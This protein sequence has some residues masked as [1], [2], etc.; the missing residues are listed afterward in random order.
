MQQRELGSEAGLEALPQSFY[1]RDA[2]DVA[3]DLI[4]CY[5]VRLAPVAG[6]AAG[7]A[8]GSG[9]GLAG[10]LAARIV[11]TEAYLPD[12]PASHSYRGR[13]LRTAAM[14]GPAG[15]AYVYFIYGTHYCLN[16][17]VG[18]EAHGAAVLLRAAVPVAGLPEMAR[19]RYFSG[20]HSATQ[21]RA[22]VDERMKGRD[23]RLVN[24]S[25]D[26]FSR[27]IRE[28]PESEASVA[29][30][31]WMLDGQRLRG[32]CNGPGKLAQAFDVGP[33]DNGQPLTDRITREAKRPSMLAMT[34]G[35]R[36]AAAESNRRLRAAPGFLLVTRSV[37][38]NLIALWL[39]QLRSDNY[40][41]F[42]TSVTRSRWPAHKRDGRVD[43]AQAAYDAIA[44][45]MVDDLDRRVVADRRVGISRAAE[46]PWRFLVTDCQFV[47]RRPG[48]DA[49]PVARER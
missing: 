19:R 46:R 3:R 30:R 2:R 41:I 8:T 38:A 32:L 12:D 7:A 34:K 27:G 49:R 35:G 4:G 25:V 42:E 33:A 22:G 45:A 13:T 24:R 20:R 37:P 5:L 29:P 17:V 9:V 6:M 48:R 16:T 18:P 40:G 15:H 1:Q 28:A 10:T 31:V 23:D 39:E 11:E 47:S 43:Q 44:S 14:F 21:S 36:P 26:R